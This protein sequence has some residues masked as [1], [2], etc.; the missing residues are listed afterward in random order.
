[1]CTVPAI[2]G[3]AGFTKRSKKNSRAVTSAVDA[4][5]WL[6]HASAVP[7]APGARLALAFGAPGWSTPAAT[8]RQFRQAPGFAVGPAIHLRLRSRARHFRP[9]KDS[10]SVLS[11][12]RCQ[13]PRFRARR[14][15][16]LPEG[17][18]GRGRF[19]IDALQRRWDGTDYGAGRQDRA[20]GPGEVDP[21]AIGKRHPGVG[22]A[23][24]VRSMQGQRS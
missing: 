9:G 8:P 7:F 21:R 18:A 22:D 17:V 4:G 16:G 1:M 19:S 11:I 24:S 10:T 6:F 20:P 15:W 23:K 2:W 14:K 5:K 13:N 12:E 3:P